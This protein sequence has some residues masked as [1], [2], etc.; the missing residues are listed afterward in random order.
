MGGSAGD[1]YMFLREA[2][3][4][5][6]LQRLTSQVDQRLIKFAGLRLTLALGVKTAGKH[7]K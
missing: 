3:D 5:R 2:E 1:E 6:L 4:F 7:W